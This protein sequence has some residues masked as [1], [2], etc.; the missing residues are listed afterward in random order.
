MNLLFF[1]TP[2][3]D[4]AYL[5][6]DFTLRQALEKM[7]YH[8]Y[9]SIPILNPA[10]EYVGTITEGDILWF[11][12]KNSNLNLQDAENTPI[13]KIPR[14]RDYKCVQVETS[15]DDLVS[16]AMT[17]NFVP[18]IDGKNSFIGLVK[19]NSIIRYCYEKAKK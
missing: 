18:V 10:G 4:V 15:M 7:E 2:K 5:E 1:L 16:T 6:D 3:V 13:M 8:R 12:K 9:S 17:Q 14:K 11:I 19:R